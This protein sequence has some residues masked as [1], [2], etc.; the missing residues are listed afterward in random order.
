MSDHSKNVQHQ[1]RETDIIL[2]A[3]KRDIESEEHLEKI[4]KIEIDRM[5]R[6]ICQFNK[7]IA[8]MEAKDS[9]YEV[10]LFQTTL[11]T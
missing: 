9:Q 7:Q 1:L 5:N 6:D 8:D 11:N 3:S 10:S 4:N 2:A